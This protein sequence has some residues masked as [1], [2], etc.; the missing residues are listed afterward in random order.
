[1]HRVVALDSQKD[2]AGGL[3]MQGRSWL[4][5]EFKNT[6]GNLMRFCPKYK[7]QRRLRIWLKL[8][9][10][11]LASYSQGLVFKL[12][13]RQKWG[14]SSPNDSHSRVSLFE[15][16]LTLQVESF[17]PIRSL[18]WK[19]ASSHPHKESVLLLDAA[20]SSAMWARVCDRVLWLT[21]WRCGWLWINDPGHESWKGFPLSL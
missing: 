8:R 14:T 2:E 19:L 5:R 15:D 16:F 21:L 11:A 1:M 12:Q 17:F 13:R 18:S 3:Q 10:R 7:L 20:L 4:Q 6:L 9:V